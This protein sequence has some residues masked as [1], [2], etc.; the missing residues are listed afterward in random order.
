[1]RGGLISRAREIREK[2]L[3]ALTAIKVELQ[4]VDAEHAKSTEVV[5][6]AIDHL[7]CGGTWAELR[8]KLGLGP[9]HIDRR[10][11]ELRSAVCDGL[12]PKTE[13][14]AL[15]AQADGREFYVHKVDELIE[16]LDAMMET[17]PDDDE[18]RKLFPSFMKLKLES[19][20]VQLEE[21]AKSFAAFVEL[22]KVRELDKKTQG[23]SFIIQN[24]YHIARPG[25]SP[26]DVEALA[27]KAIELHQTKSQ[28]KEALG[29]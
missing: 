28:L 20:K 1:M 11:R 7:A 3:Q 18:G 4:V 29:D 23:T 8:A 9:S 16:D 17:V 15:K 24:N 14:E 13:E 12:A 10:W 22:R 6:F 21:N 5:Q 27:E 26:K 19:L 25:Q 2:K